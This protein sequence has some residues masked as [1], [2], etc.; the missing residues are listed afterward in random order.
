M[1]DSIESDEGWLCDAH[2][3]EH[4]EWKHAVDG[5]CNGELLANILLGL[6]LW[7]HALQAQLDRL[8][9]SSFSWHLMQIVLLVG[10]HRQ[11]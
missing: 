8:R 2:G 11:R 5:T 10:I 7:L 1:I 6:L 9:S 4:L 3:E